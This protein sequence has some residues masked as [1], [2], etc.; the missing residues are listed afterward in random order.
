MSQTHTSID[1][2]PMPPVDDRGMA[3]P[4]MPS[5]FHLIAARLAECGHCTRRCPGISDCVET[6]V[7]EPRPA[8]D[9]LAI[10]PL[11]S[12]NFSVF[13]PSSHR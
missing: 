5:Q 3:A 1:C 8:E 4:Q 2:F 6:F 7:F 9:L 11:L 10:Q 13:T 12:L